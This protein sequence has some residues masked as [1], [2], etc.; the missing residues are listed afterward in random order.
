MARPWPPSCATRL[1]YLTIRLTAQA[2][3]SAER[4][5]VIL[6]ALSAF[7]AGKRVPVVGTKGR[8]TVLPLLCYSPGMLPDSL[9]IEQPAALLAYLR[10][11]GRIG[12]DETP[13][14]QSLQGGVS[15]RTVLVERPTGDA[16]VLKQALAKLRVAVDW[17]SSPARIHREALGLRWLPR[18]APPETVPALVFEDETQYL[19]AMQAVPQPHVNWKTL[20]LGGGLDPAHVVQFGALLAAIHR[21][22]YERRAEL[23]P[24]F[25]DRSFFE[26]LR[27]EPYY[28]YA[29]GQVPASAAFYASLIAAT[30]A[31]S[32]TLVHGD[33]S[34]KNILVHQG[35]LVLLDHE[36]IHWGDPAFDLGFSLTHLLSK[37]HHLP[38]HRAA[39]ADAA[40]LYWRTYLDSL[41][42]VPWRSD[43]EPRAVRHTLGCLLARVAG[44]SPLEY[45]SPAAR[46]RQRAAVVALMADPPPHVPELVAMFVARLA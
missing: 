28:S 24:L 41:G 12:P 13:R 17:F 15:N 39:L 33:Y 42:P 14:V 37:A 4:T 31:T 40:R 3:K 27:V 46:D 5:I 36:V 1:P 26:S 7:S 2:A 21:G 20:L 22:A 6:S 44:R 38:A 25:A 43:L 29:A 10:A 11:T 9:D 19:L 35:R 23:A 45:L 8:L 18:L 30:R 32:L 34:P 16:W